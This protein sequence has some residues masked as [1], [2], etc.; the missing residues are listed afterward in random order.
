MT[1]QRQTGT[2]P[3]RAG[4]WSARALVGGIVAT[5]ILLGVALYGIG[6]TIID[7]DNNTAASVP[8]TTGAGTAR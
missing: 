2:E 6:K 8:R 1:T 5:M 4:A 7:A 3:A